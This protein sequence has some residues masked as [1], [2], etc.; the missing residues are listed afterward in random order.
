MESLLELLRSLPPIPINEP[1][2]EV[3]PSFKLSKEAGKGVLEGKFG[4]AFIPSKGDYYSMHPFG[5][6]QPLNEK[7]LKSSQRGLFG[8]E[9]PPRKKEG[10]YIH[11]VLLFLIFL[12]IIAFHNADSRNC[13]CRLHIKLNERIIKWAMIIKRKKKKLWLDEVHWKEFSIM[14]GKTLKNV[15]ISSDLSMP[16]HLELQ[17]MSVPYNL[18][19]W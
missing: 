19:Q 1:P 5:D 4:K 2:A 8:T 7:N 18:I 14:K 17:F 12:L 11:C 3:T 9:F 15:V 10:M 6:L 16:Q 13:S